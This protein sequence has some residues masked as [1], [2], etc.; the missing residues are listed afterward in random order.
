MVLY[1]GGAALL[2]D[3][4][5]LTSGCV[6]AH[7]IHFIFFAQS[8]I[9]EH[10]AIYLHK[11]ISQR[12]LSLSRLTTSAIGSAEHLACPWIM[13]GMSSSNLNDAQNPLP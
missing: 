3:P 6:T 10:S 9:L 13:N 4:Q 2:T 12:R 1:L 8:Q 5:I 11:A 7:F